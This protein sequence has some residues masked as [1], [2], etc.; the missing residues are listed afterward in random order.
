MARANLR[1]VREIV[2]AFVALSTGP[3]Y[4]L[5][6]W[7]FEGLLVLDHWD[8]LDVVFCIAYHHATQKVFAVHGK[9]VLFVYCLKWI[10]VGQRLHW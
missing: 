2:S 3:Y 8:Q 10:F 1:I 9:Q 5:A 4:E 6:W 7:Y